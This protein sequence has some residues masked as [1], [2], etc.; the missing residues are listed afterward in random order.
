ISLA[1]RALDALATQLLTGHG[2]D[3]A[4][5]RLLALEL[6]ER[7]ALRLEA[8]NLLDLAEVAERLANVLFCNATSDVSDVHRRVVVRGLFVHILVI[9]LA[10]RPVARLVR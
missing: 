1:P 6:D 3:G 5:R 7:V 9:H 2:D 4:R 8:S 10:T